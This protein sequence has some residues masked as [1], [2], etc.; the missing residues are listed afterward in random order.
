MTERLAPILRH[1]PTEPS[2][3]CWQWHAPEPWFD[4]DF[5]VLTSYLSGFRTEEAAE[6]YGARNRWVR[7]DR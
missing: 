3:I 7:N 5:K 2:E 1:I 4:E 6:R